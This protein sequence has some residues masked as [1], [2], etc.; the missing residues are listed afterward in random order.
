MKKLIALTFCLALLGT[1]AQ[2]QSSA[3]TKRVV[4]PKKPGEM[5]TVKKQPSPQ[6]LKMAN[7]GKAVDQKV[8]DAKRKVTLRVYL[9]NRSGKI[10][11]DSFAQGEAVIMG[12]NETGK[13]ILLTNRALADDITLLDTSSNADAR[14]MGKIV[15]D[16]KALLV[17]IS[18]QG[19]GPSGLLLKVTMP[20]GSLG[21]FPMISERR[22]L[23]LLELK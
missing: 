23:E 9:A 6:E 4:S 17:G 18:V 11:S 8:T 1:A 19:A 5:S 13:L 22:A 14:Y 12:T 2:A 21:N 10:Y 20:S 7:V 3:E 15:T 16:P